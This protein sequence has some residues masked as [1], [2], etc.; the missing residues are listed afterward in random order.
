[1]KATLGPVWP[2]FESRSKA[3]IRLL[4]DVNV[5]CVAAPIIHPFILRLMFEGGVN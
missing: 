3:M 1:M 5:K 2:L 4:H